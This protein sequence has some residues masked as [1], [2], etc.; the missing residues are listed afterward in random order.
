MG[1]TIKV[2]QACLS[3]RFGLEP[4]GSRVWNILIRHGFLSSS[5][6][7]PRRSLCSRPFDDPPIQSHNAEIPFRPSPNLYGVCSET[8]LRDCHVI[9]RRTCQSFHRD[10]CSSS[11]SCF[12]P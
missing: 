12:D 3:A 11:E 9:S 4:G 6:Q 5:A 7:P 8:L 2:K 1:S 10:L